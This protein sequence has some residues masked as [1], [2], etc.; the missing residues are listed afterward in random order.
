MIKLAVET[1]KGSRLSR[2]PLSEDYTPIGVIQPGEKCL[3]IKDYQG[4]KTNVDKNQAEKILKECLKNL[5]GKNAMEN[6]ESTW[7]KLSPENEVIAKNVSYVVIAAAA[8]YFS[9]GFFKGVFNKGKIYVEKT[10]AAAK[11]SDGKKVQNYN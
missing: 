4:W 5:K 11:T 1:A 10:R 3:V 6:H 7:R 8:I 2:N 9:R